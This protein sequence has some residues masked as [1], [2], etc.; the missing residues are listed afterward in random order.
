MTDFLSKTEDGKEFPADW[1]T[2]IMHIYVIK[3]KKDNIQRIIEGVAKITNCV[4]NTFRIIG[5]GIRE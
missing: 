4:K 1:N 2:T 5:G 3:N